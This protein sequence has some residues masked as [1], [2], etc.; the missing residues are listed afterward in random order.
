MSPLQS[1]G[2]WCIRKT[3]IC[4]AAKNMGVWDGEKET[5]SVKVKQFL[6]TPGTARNG[7]SEL[8][9]PWSGKLL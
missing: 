1:T 6:G 5:N 8:R 3:R 9:A 7:L 2:G 4:Y